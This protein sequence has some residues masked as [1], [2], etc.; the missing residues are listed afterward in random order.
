MNSAVADWCFLL[1]GPGVCLPHCWGGGTVPPPSGGEGPRRCTG[2]RWHSRCQDTAD[3]S[4]RRLESAGSRVKLDLNRKPDGK[5]CGAGPSCVPNLHL[6]VKSAEI[7]VSSISIGMSYA[8]VVIVEQLKLQHLRLLMGKG[9]KLLLWTRKMYT[10]SIY[11]G[12]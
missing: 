6:K 12:K 9:R 3:G 5:G 4:G 11:N 2:E 8:K 1:P 7:T 10:I